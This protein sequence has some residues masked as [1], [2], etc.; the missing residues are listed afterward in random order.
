MDKK[1]YN[2]MIEI[3]KECKGL[4]FKR[5]ISYFEIYKNK[6]MIFSDGNKEFRLVKYYEI[7]DM[8]AYRE[9]DRISNV[10]IEFNQSHIRVSFIQ[11]YPGCAS[12]ECSFTVDAELILGNQKEFEKY[13]KELEERINYHNKD[14]Q[15]RFDSQKK[16]KEDSILKKERKEYERLKAKFG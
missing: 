3:Q 1:T 13:L 2:E 11:D 7:D 10:V 12:E 16:D 6:K 4:F 5:F 14:I 8:A 9:N 15:A